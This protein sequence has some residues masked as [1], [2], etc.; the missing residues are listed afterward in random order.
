MITGIRETSERNEFS[1]KNYS[2]VF[3]IDYTYKNISSADSMYISDMNFKI[4]DETGE[5]GGTYPDT[6][7]ISLK[8]PQEIIAGTTCKAQMLLGIS[9]RSNKIQLQYWGSAWDNQPCAIFELNV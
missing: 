7:S 8:Y 3:I 9:N 6:Y 5:I 1:N 2:Q 4:I